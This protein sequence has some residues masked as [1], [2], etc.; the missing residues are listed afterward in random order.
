MG[1]VGTKP[2]A[3]PLTSAQLEDGL[4]TAA[5]LATDA[6]E[7]AKVKDL[8]VTVAK[9]PAAVDISTKTV[10]L[11]ASVSGLGTG[12]DVTSQI[13]GT[14]PTANLGSGAAAASTYLAGNQTYQTITEYD[15]SVL[16]SNIAMLG[17]KV[18]VN[19]SLTRYNLVDQSIDEFYDT[20]GVDASASTNEQRVASGSN[21]YYTG[22][23]GTN[24][25]GG[26]S[27]DSSVTGYTTLVFTS[28]G[29]LTIVD[30]GDVD[31]LVVAGAGSGGNS[32]GGGGGA[33][34][35]VY[36]TGHAVTTN[37]YDMVIGDGGAAQTSAASVGNVGVDSTW[38]INGGAVEFTAKGGGFGAQQN[39]AAGAGG[40]G[41][42][43]G[44]NVDNAGSSTQGAQAGDSGTYGFGYAGGE[45]TAAPNYNGGGGGGA[46]S[47]GGAGNGSSG[48]GGTGKDLSAIFGTAV[49]DSGWFASG[50]GG[51]FS[52]DGSDGVGT[53]SAG[54]GGRGALDGS[55]AGTAGTANTGGGGGGG[56]GSGAGTGAGG[57]GGV[58]V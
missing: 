28:S 53:V 24:P 26:N 4:V 49:G 58:L 43:S 20:S 41:G 6:V 21:F 38:T 35:L 16:Q 57:K 47:V 8:N 30:G 51:S 42:G 15:D 7:T 11:P 27:T 52:N 3:A 33:G 23:S 5:K 45:G 29:A 48:N 56:S 2:T 14:V 40:S 34:G 22:A 37:T 9:L 36:K 50:G 25:S 10:T 19:G 32:Y 13:T 44:H 39:D 1:Y 31:V 46:G 55:S 17:F 12:I 54:G 18:A